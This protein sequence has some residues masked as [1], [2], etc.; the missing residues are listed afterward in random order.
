[1]AFAVAAGLCGNDTDAVPGQV[2]HF[3]FYTYLNMIG[4]F[5]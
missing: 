3:F 2:I 4:L 1:M 5:G